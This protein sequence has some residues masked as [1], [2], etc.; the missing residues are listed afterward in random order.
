ME[1]TFKNEIVSKKETSL[2]AFDAAK[3]HFSFD[4]CKYSAVI[5]C[6][7][8]GFDDIVFP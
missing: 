2:N 1:I 5:F 6:H 8:F 3:V 7:N 4:T